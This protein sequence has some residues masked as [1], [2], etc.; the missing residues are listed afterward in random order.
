VFN[1]AMPM[2]AWFL[3]RSEYRVLI[4][5]DAKALMARF[6]DQAYSEARERQ[7]VPPVGDDVRR[8]THLWERVK[9]AIRRTE[10]RR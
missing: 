5:A 1:I 7:R 8:P 4:E 6:G 3:R 10:A 9:E 2:F